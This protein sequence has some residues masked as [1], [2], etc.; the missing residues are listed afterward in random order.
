MFLL[1]LAF[2][3]VLLLNNIYLKEIEVRPVQLSEVTKIAVTPEGGYNTPIVRE[4][5][6]LTSSIEVGS[7]SGGTGGVLEEYNVE[8]TT[9]CELLTTADALLGSITQKFRWYRNYCCLQ[10]SI[11]LPKLA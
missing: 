11:S 8:P 1:E 7:F 6:E 10:W 9:V 2:Q 3:Q 4:N 5:L